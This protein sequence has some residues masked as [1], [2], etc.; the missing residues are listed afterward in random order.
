M[1]PV[2]KLPYLNPWQVL[3]KLPPFPKS[4]WPH[5]SW[6]HWVMTSSILTC[7]THSCFLCLRVAW[8]KGCP[9]HGVGRLMFMAYLEWVSEGCLLCPKRQGHKHWQWFGTS[10]VPSI[11]F[12]A[13]NTSFPLILTIVLRKGKHFYSEMTFRF[14]SSHFCRKDVPS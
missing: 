8:R 3:C 14:S 7:V 11:M 1:T 10:C 12:C 4:V 9:Y 5:F 2:C 6:I 13:S